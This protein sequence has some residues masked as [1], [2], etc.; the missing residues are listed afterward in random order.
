MTNGT[1]KPAAFSPA[2]SPVLRRVRCW[3]LSRRASSASTTRSPTPTR[4]TPAAGLS[5]RHRRR[6]PAA[7]SSVRFPVVGVPARGHPPGAVHRQSLARR[8]M[9]Q[10]AGPADSGA[11]ED[12][13]RGGRPARRIRP[14][15]AAAIRGPNARRDTRLG[16]RRAIRAATQALDQLLVLGTL[17]E[18]H[19]EHVMDAVGPAVVP[20][21]ATIRGRFDE[22]RQRK[23]PP[24][25]AA[26]ARAAGRGRQTQPV[27]PRQGVRRPGGG[28][29]RNEAVQHDLDRPRD[30]A[31]ARRDRTAAAM[32]RQGAVAQ[33]RGPQTHSRRRSWLPETATVVRGPVRWARIR[34]R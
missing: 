12:I 8:H 2:G 24:L 25:T 10:R 28:P 31:A 34:W 18:G 3:R 29:G 5:Q 33:L 19:A 1:E 6:A 14:C 9:S 21:V 32:D 7:R 13:R 11:A 16:A 15:R 4:A 30:A 22:R 20:S 27:H 23:Q 26:V 17:L